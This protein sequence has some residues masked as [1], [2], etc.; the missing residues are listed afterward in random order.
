MNYLLIPDKFKGSLTAQEVIDALRNGIGKADPGAV[1]HSAVVSDGGDGFLESISH[2]GQYETVGCEARNPLGKTIHASYLFD[3]ATHSAYIEM[4]QTAGLVLL[5]EKDRNPLLTSTY[6]TGMQIRHALE[7]GARNIF[8]GLGGSATNDAGLGIAAAMGYRFL[9]GNGRVLEPEGQ[10]LSR[11]SA[12]QKPEDDSLYTTAKI[13]AINDVNNSLYGPQ[14]AA[15]VY[16]AQKGANA[17]DIRLLDKGLRDFAILVNQEMG[18]DYASI[19]GAGAAGGTAYG[20]MSFLGAHFLGGT[21]FVLSMA[22]VNELLAKNTIH[23]IITGEGKI[24]DQTLSGK[25]IHGVLELGRSYKIP[26]IAVCGML[27]T[28]KDKL[29]DAGMSSVIEVRNTSE[30]LAFNMENAA[31]LVT[32]AVYDFLQNNPH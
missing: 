23:Y 28:D 17:D 22:G 30:S 32:T 24:D 12:I 21:E 4:A 5:D 1:M 16:A 3:Q 2:Y 26:V 13:Y 11:I 27:D 29:L 19:P 20:L 9:D 31:K 8:I 25:L 10:N 15:Y 6:G 14:G 18:I 7:K